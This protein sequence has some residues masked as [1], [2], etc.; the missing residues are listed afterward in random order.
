MD[1]KFNGD[2]HPYDG[3][4]ASFLYDKKDTPHK[5]EAGKPNFGDS[6]KKNLQSDGISYLYQMCNAPA[7]SANDG[8]FGWESHY[9]IQ[10]S[11]FHDYCE[12]KEYQLENGDKN[13]G[14][15]QYDPTVFP[16][17]S[18]FWHAKKAKD[19]NDSGQYAP[20]LQVSYAGNFFMSKV[21]WELGQW[22]P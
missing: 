19:S 16:V 9:N 15:K 22:Q 17:I 1:K 18:C 8:W 11:D 4:N 3:N 21:Q 5:D 13:N 14:Y 10:Y 20:A 7:S 12:V 2:P 6:K